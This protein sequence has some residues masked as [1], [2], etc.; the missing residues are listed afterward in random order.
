MGALY[1]ALTR[2]YQDLFII[3]S[4]NLTTYLDPVPK[5]LFEVVNLNGYKTTAISPMEEEDDLPF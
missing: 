4:Q 2:T 5:Q 3:Y 1:V